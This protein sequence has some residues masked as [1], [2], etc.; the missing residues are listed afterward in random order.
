MALWFFCF[1]YNSAIMGHVMGLYNC[2][3]IGTL[4]VYSYSRTLNAWYQVPN[5][6]VLVLVVAT[7]FSRYFS[8]FVRPYRTKFAY[9]CAYLNKL[10]RLYG[11]TKFST[12]KTS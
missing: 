4:H 6:A 2:S 7:K 1:L 10:E 5:T 12:T 11:R 8:F 3:S 9:G